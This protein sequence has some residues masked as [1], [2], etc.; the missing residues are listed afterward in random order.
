ME[1]DINMAWW[2][3]DDYDAL[4][5]DDGGDNGDGDDGGDNGD[6][7]YG[8]DNGDGDGHDDDDGGPLH[9]LA[10]STTSQPGVWTWCWSTE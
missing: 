5:S 7:D 9:I 10:V 4:H 6:G 1:D 8:G 2:C 3:L